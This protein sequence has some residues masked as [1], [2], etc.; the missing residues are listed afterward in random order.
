MLPRFENWTVEER[1]VYTRT[2]EV[3]GYTLYFDFDARALE[4]LSEEDMQAALEADWKQFRA[5][6]IAK[7]AQ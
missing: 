3:N 5:S 1:T 6:A 7:I 2:E 4:N